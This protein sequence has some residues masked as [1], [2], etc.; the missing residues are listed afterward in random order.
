MLFRILERQK[1]P[2]GFVVEAVLSLAFDRWGGAGYKS[3]KMAITVAHDNNTNT[4]GPRTNPRV[5]SS[6]ILE[7][8]AWIIV[9]EKTVP[10]A[11][12]GKPKDPGLAHQLTQRMRRK[13][14]RRFEVC[15]E[16]QNNHQP[17]L[18]LKVSPLALRFRGYV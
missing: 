4:N 1:H 15:V 10:V 7:R 17:Y 14:N 12:I 11:I 9:V 5:I 6:A 16:V 3:R 8:A 18:A 13:V 2:R